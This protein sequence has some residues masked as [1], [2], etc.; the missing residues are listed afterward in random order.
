MCA[1]STETLWVECECHFNAKMCLICIHTGIV[2]V[3]EDAVGHFDLGI[4]VASIVPN[5]PADRDGRIRAGKESWWLAYRWLLMFFLFYLARNPN[6]SIKELRVVQVQKSMWGYH[7]S[8]FWMPA[9]FHCD[10]CLQAVAWSPWTISAWK[11]SP[12]ARQRR[13]YTTALRR[14]SSSSHSQKVPYVHAIV[15]W[16]T[17]STL[18]PCLC[19]SNVK[20][21]M[22]S[23]TTWN[24]LVFSLKTRFWL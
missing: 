18:W 3:G 14:C 22:V 11:A 6:T 15:D 2:I 19:Y 20:C 5:G 16:S 7:S 12:S 1:V 17:F 13:S 9:V 8:V 23:T 10:L 21:Y 4:F 24:L